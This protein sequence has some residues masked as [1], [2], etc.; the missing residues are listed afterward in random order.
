LITQG[1]DFVGNTALQGGQ[2]LINFYDSDVLHLSLT[3]TPPTTSSQ[4]V[5]NGLVRPLGI[6]SGNGISNAPAMAWLPLQIPANAAAMAFDFTVNGNPMDDWLVCGIGTNN[7]F[8]LQA[9]YIPTNQVSASRLIDV[10]AWAGT[11]N[12]LF[13]GFLGGTS[14]NATLEIDNIRFYSLELP[15]LQAQMSGGNLILSW[16]MS[17]QNFSLQTTTNLADP[18]SWQTLTNVPAIVNLQNTVTNPIVGSQGFYR[19]IQSQ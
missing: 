18:N 9:Q 17:S 14:T 3:T 19:L 13:F 10:T 4:Q 12:E 7:L 5:Q 8:S 6:P 1:F 15:S 11:T 16:P 2:I